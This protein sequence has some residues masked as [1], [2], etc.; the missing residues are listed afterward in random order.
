MT[1]AALRKLAADYTREAGVR[2]LERLLAKVFRK[3]A[4]RLSG[5][6]ARRRSWS[7]SRICGS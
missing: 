3:V 4:T 2:Q 6:H 5:R 1:D 7:T